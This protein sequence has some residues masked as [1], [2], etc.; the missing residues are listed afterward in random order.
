MASQFETVENSTSPFLTSLKTQLLKLTKKPLLLYHHHLLKL[1]NSLWIYNCYP[2]KPLRNQRNLRIGSNPS[3]RICDH[4]CKD[5]LHVKLTGITVRSHFKFIGK[6]NHFRNQLF[7][8]LVW[9]RHFLS[10]WHLI[11]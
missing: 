2:L 3:T 8:D 5:L 4:H 10:F 6:G 1:D 11:N 9:Y 7:F